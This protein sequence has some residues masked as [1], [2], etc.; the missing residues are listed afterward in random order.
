MFDI[1]CIFTTGGVVLWCKAF[2]DLRLDILNIF[3]KNILLEEKTAQSQYNYQDYVLKWKVQNDLKLVFAIVY[4]E[5][6]QL[7][8]T[9]ELLEMIRYEFVSKIYPSLVK[10]GEIYMTLPTQFDQHY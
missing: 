1:V 2:C 6:M 8:F 3:I 7:G 9:E 10:Q 4:K 5:I